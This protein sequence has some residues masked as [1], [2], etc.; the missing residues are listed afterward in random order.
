VVVSTNKLKFFSLPI[1][2]YN[3]K[4]WSCVFRLGLVGICKL[5]L[6]YSEPVDE[7]K[8]TKIINNKGLLN[9]IH[10]AAVKLTKNPSIEEE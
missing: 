8:I 1:K 3:I 7:S 6:A 5:Q 4:N 2:I 10:A 9:K